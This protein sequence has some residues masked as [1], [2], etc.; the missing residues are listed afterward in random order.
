MEIKTTTD[1]TEFKKC[2]D[3]S[4]AELPTALKLASKSGLIKME[5]QMKKN[6]SGGMLDRGSGTLEKEITHSVF[7]SKGVITGKVG[8]PYEGNQG[9]AFYGLF[10][11][12][13]KS[14]TYLRKNRASAGKHTV[15]RKIKARPWSTSV[16]DKYDGI[17][18]NDLA[19][20]AGKV[21][22]GK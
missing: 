4:L 10:F 5:T 13:I 14:M 17:I 8:L 2:Y 3:N 18:F 6:V 7:T 22:D 15:H 16:M 20:I 1:F 9:D 11:E 12:H 21:F 19:G